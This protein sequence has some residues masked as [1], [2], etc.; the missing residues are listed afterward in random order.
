MT[1]GIKPAVSINRTRLW[2]V[3]VTVAIM[4]V[5][6]ELRMLVT[7]GMVV[8]QLTS[9]LPPFGYFDSSV[10]F[11]PDKMT[12]LPEP[13]VFTVVFSDVCPVTK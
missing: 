9:F 7:E 2:F 12:T 1:A 3:H 5:G 8:R 13:G 10:T 6:M 4:K 11:V